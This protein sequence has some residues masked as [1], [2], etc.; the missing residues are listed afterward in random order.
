MARALLVEIKQPDM[1]LKFSAFIQ[2]FG[3]VCDYDFLLFLPMGLIKPF[4]L[5]LLGNI[6]TPLYKI[7]HLFQADLKNLSF[8]LCLKE[9]S[10]LAEY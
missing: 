7:H 9:H 6:I 8:H 10:G 5:I 2:I 4:D 1:G 3:M